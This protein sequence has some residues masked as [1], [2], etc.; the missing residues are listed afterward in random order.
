MTQRSRRSE[1]KEAEGKE[2]E[3][4]FGGFFHFGTSFF[5]FWCVFFTSVLSFFVFGIFLSLCVSCFLFLDL[6][7]HTGTFGFCFACCGIFFVCLILF[8]CLIYILFA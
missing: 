1:E 5:C 6:F 3:G 8:F 2:R 7:F 4:I